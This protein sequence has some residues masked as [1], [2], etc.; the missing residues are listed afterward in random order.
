MPHQATSP[1][2]PEPRLLYIS[3]VAQR[4]GLTQRT[5]RYYEEIGLLDPPQRMEG[6]FRL[7]SEDDIQR[8]TRIVEL[9]RLLGFSLLEIK[10]LVQAEELREQLR[11]EFKRESDPTAR[12]E[13]LERAIQTVE[14]QLDKVNRRLD[15][16]LALRSKLDARLARLRGR[17]AELDG[18]E[19][20]QMNADERR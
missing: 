10:E 9:K 13:T 20:P 18:I 3:E 5:L 1:T 17:M 2:P 8:I 19:E 16:M 7:Y 15:Q 14:F 4:T 11:D 12:R 6:G